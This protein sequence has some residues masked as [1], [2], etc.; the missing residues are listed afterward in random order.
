MATV[1]MLPCQQLGVG[2][3][4]AQSPLL[5]DQVSECSQTVLKQCGHCLKEEP[6]SSDLTSWGLPAV[7]LLFVIGVCQHIQ[8]HFWSQWLALGQFSETAHLIFETK[9]LT[10][11]WGSPIQG[12]PGSPRFASSVLGLRYLHQTSFLR[13]FAES[14][15]GCL[16]CVGS[17]SPAEPLPASFSCFFI[18]KTYFFS[19][20]LDCFACMFICM[21]GNHRETSIFKT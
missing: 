19:C 17:A 15:S 11:A 20:V 13:G 9:S 3:P 21:S 16:A 1:L 12:A 5:P 10:G 14:N 8:R 7:L 6:N 2:G 18:L 4:G